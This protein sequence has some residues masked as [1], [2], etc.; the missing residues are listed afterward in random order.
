MRTPDG[1]GPYLTLAVGLSE[2]ILNWIL[3]AI[4]MQTR[5]QSTTGVNV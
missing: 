1:V 5:Q 4:L 3:K 2:T